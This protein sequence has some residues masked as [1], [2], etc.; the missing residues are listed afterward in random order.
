MKLTTR[1]RYGTRAVLDLAIHAA[2]RPVSLKDIAQRQ[3]ISR[4]Y[5]ETLFSTLQSS[6]IV[7]AV[8]GPRGGYRLT[9]K[10]EDISL[11]RLYEVLEGSGPLVDC[12][13]DPD[14]CLRSA[15][16]VTQ[17]VWEEMYNLCV[18]YL[19]SISIQELINRS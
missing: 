7:R 18:G 19:E 1:F 6:G 17:K 13:A 4:K 3:G 8:R 16:C 14:I 11:R 9:R 12:T 5:L 2:E 15:S 10:P